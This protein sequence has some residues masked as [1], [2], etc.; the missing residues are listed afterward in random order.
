M[1]EAQKKIRIEF[2]KVLA[3][4]GDTYNELADQLAKKAVGL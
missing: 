2:V 4:S 1:Q 3:H